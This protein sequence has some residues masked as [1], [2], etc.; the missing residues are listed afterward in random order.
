LPPLKTLSLQG[1]KSKKET[2]KQVIFPLTLET[3]DLANNDLE[4]IPEGIFKLEKLNR[5]SLDHN[6]LKDLPE[7]LMEMNCLNH[8]SLDSNPLTDQDKQR[9]H[10]V[11]KIWF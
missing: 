4:Q 8:L 3:L 5:L 2:I 1:L 9:L 7:K 6:L 11:F 10:D